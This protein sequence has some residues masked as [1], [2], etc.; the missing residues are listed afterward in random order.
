MPVP[1]VGEHDIPQVTASRYVPPGCSI[2]RCNVRGAW[3]VHMPP[4]PRHSEAWANWQGD[5]FAAM[6]A[7]ARWAWRQYLADHALPLDHCPIVGM[8]EEAA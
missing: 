1:A 6:K 8:L 2:W 3:S 4:H 7:G 5:S